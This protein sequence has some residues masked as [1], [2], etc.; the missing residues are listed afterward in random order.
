MRPSRRGAIATPA[1]APGARGA[2]AAHSAQGVT[3]H[4][5]ER[6]PQAQL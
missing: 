4:A 1:P 6:L 5:R 2:G 3:L